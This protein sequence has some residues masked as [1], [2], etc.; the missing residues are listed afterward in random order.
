MSTDRVSGDGGLMVVSHVQR[1]VN[2]DCVPIMIGF[3]IR[4]PR[5]DIVQVHTLIG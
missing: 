1:M 2:S 3:W 4:R 5:S